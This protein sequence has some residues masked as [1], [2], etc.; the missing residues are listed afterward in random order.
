MTS[1]P[2]LHSFFPSQ[3][4][5]SGR[6][7]TLKSVP[8]VEVPIDL[9]R[10]ASSQQQQ[11]QPPQS[12]KQANSETDTVRAGVKRR[13]EFSR[14]LEDDVLST[15]KRSKFSPSRP[16]VRI[17][18]NLSAPD[19]LQLEEVP[20]ELQTTTK[21][22]VRGAPSP[23]AHGVRRF[24]LRS[25]RAPQQKSQTS[26]DLEQS[27]VAVTP[28]DISPNAEV[29]AA[30]SKT[31]MSLA[32]D[33]GTESS[34][35]GIAQEE[36]VLSQYPRSTGNELESAVEIR[37]PTNKRPVKLLIKD[38][39]PQI[40]DPSEFRFGSSTPAPALPSPRKGPVQLQNARTDL[41][42]R[43]LAGGPPAYQRYKHLLGTERKL[44][45]PSKYEVLE[46]MFCGLENV[47]IYNGGRDQACIF[48]KIRD[49][50]SR[51]A[52][53]NFELS[54]LA[55]IRTV[56]PEAYTYKPVQTIAKGVRV[57]SVAIG[58]PV[59]NKTAMQKGLSSSATSSAG[60]G[61]SPIH[62]G[63]LM[64]VRRGEFHRRLLGR[65]R[66]FH[67]EFLRTL[68]YALEKEDE[69]HALV[70]WHPKFDLEGVPN[71]A[72]APMPELESMQDTRLESMQ[73]IKP[74]VSMKKL[75]ASQPQATPKTNDDTDKTITSSPS[76]QN[77]EKDEINMV[78]KPK[79]SR[80][81]ALLERIRAKERQKVEQQMFTKKASPA[82][83]KRKAMLSR[84]PDV[85]YTLIMLYASSKR[86]VM[87]LNHVVQ[88]VANS[89]ESALSLVEVE[90]HIKLAA[91]VVPEWCKVLE[92][93]IGAQLKI[94]RA[95]P[96]KR[97]QEKVRETLAAT[98]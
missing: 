71:I 34:A 20:V 76:I 60:T 12:A 50:V 88:H 80:A 78:A 11:Q 68:P 77:A 47:M 48:H 18:S 64:D 66:A 44:I 49:P 55:Q 1:S 75:D 39:D 95:T 24:L 79:L 63:K 83:I 13:H 8:S 29:D 40:H 67:Q 69:C 37:T 7:S 94:D 38:D 27:T 25:P 36:V 16:Q 10:R 92:L 33:G 73:V 84:L 81:Q 46:K 85:A 14:E 74:K 41:K 57:T 91:E 42:A 59:D 53:R 21:G 62:A 23:I 87:P 56:Y 96:L 32:R 72:P 45:L 26:E 98:S 54:H 93:D 97:V 15:P 6:R 4:P 2:S 35:V 28:N 17:D 22:D 90:E 43:L 30:V 19:E 31:E 86:N 58:L 61:S 65:V 89:L 3:K 5:A 70:S 82:D 52:N 51:I 9:R